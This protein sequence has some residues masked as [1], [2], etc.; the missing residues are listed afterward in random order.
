MESGAHTKILSADRG[1]NSEKITAILER[2]CDLSESQLEALA[3]EDY[4]RIS[5]LLNQKDQLLSE[6]SDARASG[7]LTLTP[8]NQ[9]LLRKFEVHEKF[10]IRRLTERASEISRRIGAVSLRRSAA[11]GYVTAASKINNLDASR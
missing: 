1:E 7:S 2:L 11:E 4:N 3:R 10:V 5:G 8:E 9:T 6:I